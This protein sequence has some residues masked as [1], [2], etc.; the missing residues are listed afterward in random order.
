M[1]L[2]LGLELP[3]NFE[4]E[5]RNKVEMLA[6]H[7][8]FKKTAFFL[9]QHISLKIAFECKDYQEVIKTLKSEVLCKYQPFTVKTRKLEVNPSIIWIRFKKSQTLIDLHDD[10]VAALEMRHGII[11]HEFDHEFIFH[12]T[13]VHDENLSKEDLKQMYK[14]L[15]KEYKRTV[16][17]MSKVIFGISEDNEPETFKI[18]DRME[19]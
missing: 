18:V 9:P 8:T 14:I 5:S 17:R 4:M 1:F 12:S 2:W 16:L 3:I 10:I 19:L 6:K 7:F 15:K 11:P 13:L